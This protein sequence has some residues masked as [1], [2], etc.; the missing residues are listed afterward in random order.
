MST[1]KLGING[2]GRI[3]RTVIREFEKRKQEGMYKNIEIV[4]VNNPGTPESF[5]MLFKYDSL[6]GKFPGEI[7][8]N[9]DT[10]T[11][12]SSHLKFFTQTDPSEIDWSSQ[13]VDRFYDNCSCLHRRSKYS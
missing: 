4:A 3:G 7:S 13:G 2:M 11:C 1:I 8:L 9:G 10:L 6:H 12:G 5:L